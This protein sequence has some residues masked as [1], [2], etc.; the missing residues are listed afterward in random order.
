MAGKLITGTWEVRVCRSNPFFAKSAS[1]SP[2]DSDVVFCLEWLCFECSARLINSF[3]WTL[4][5]QGVGRDMLIKVKDIAS[6][7]TGH[8]AHSGVVGCLKE[9][10]GNP[11]S[12]L[13]CN[14]PHIQVYATYHRT[15]WG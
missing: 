14:N 8:E 9:R 10:L 1:K 12:E 4:A 11:R 3:A 13:H 15:S 7:T 5:V 6:K 2:R